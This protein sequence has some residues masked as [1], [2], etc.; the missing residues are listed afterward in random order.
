MMDPIEIAQWFDS[1]YRGEQLQKTFQ[2]HLKGFLDD[3]PGLYRQWRLDSHEFS[4]VVIRKQSLVQLLSAL[5]TDAPTLTCWLDQLPAAVRKTI[6]IISWEGAQTSPPEKIVDTGPNDESTA[7]RFPPS[8]HHFDFPLFQHYPASQCHGSR[9]MTQLIDLPDGI[10][11]L[12]QPCFPKPEGWQLIADSD[13]AVDDTLFE[14][15]QGIL[16]IL[17]LTIQFLQDTPQLLTK[18][19][20]PRKSII[21]QLQAYGDIE[22]FFPGTIDGPLANLR[23]ELMVRLLQTIGPPAEAV[24]PLETLIHFF[25]RYRHLPFFPHLPLLSHLKGWHKTGVYYSGRT[26]RTVWGLIEDLPEDG[27]VDVDQL[28]RY[29][30][31]HNRPLELVDPR[32]SETELYYTRD[33]PQGGQEKI[34]LTY[35]RYH[36]ALRRPMVQ[37]ILATFAAFGLLDAAFSNK[38]AEP[39]STPHDRLCRIRLTP[40]GAIII[41]RRERRCL[42]KPIPEKAELR[43]DE[44]YLFI[45]LS[46]RDQS[47]EYLL[48]QLATRIGRLRYRC[49]TT[50][51]LKGCDTKDQLAEKIQRFRTK[52]AADP[53]ENWRLFLEQLPHR[54][55][56]IP[57]R[58]D[59]TVFR[60][61]AA[62]DELIDTILDDPE[63]KRLVLKAEDYHLLVRQTELAP[64]KMRLRN[65]GFLVEFDL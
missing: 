33:W 7:L 56:D 37:G 63:L 62:A 53:P 23:T 57:C 4:G 54:C 35:E 18:A 58:Q 11:R 2:C 27:W 14:D 25:E 5:F 38:T 36:A 21:R 65:L 12:L 55:F 46:C 48:D 40:L 59:L 16:R 29:A 1:A 24:D 34:Q 32:K 15:R 61:P 26:H 44:T 41:Q 39:V 43:L 13:P 42:L 30:L 6:E 19:G 47:L 51:F 17:P 9:S 22:E 52:I 10:R 8:Y 60:L 49:D 20:S 50:T 28:L 64:L 31:L 45:T 3:R